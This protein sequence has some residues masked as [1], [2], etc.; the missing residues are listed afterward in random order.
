MAKLS[1]RKQKKRAQ[2]NQR[3][4]R[5]YKPTNRFNRMLQITSVDINPR[6]RYE[7]ELLTVA[8]HNLFQLNNYVY[9]RV[10]LEAIDV[11]TLK[12]LG[13]NDF[14]KIIDKIRDLA[15]YDPN[16]Y[17]HAERG[18][19]MN[20]IT[21]AM[22]KNFKQLNHASGR[23]IIPTFYNVLKDLKSEFEKYKDKKHPEV[24]P[25]IVVSYADGNN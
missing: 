11:E 7:Q 21:Q 22:S 2:T 16:Y 6:N 20:R 4:G 24:H 8:E 10:E 14:L 13:G 18:Y 15:R 1:R 9:D 19:L 17:K 5:L 12:W 23:R 3:L 25:Y